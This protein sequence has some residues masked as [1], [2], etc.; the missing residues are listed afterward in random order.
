MLRGFE[1]SMEIAGKAKFHRFDEIDKGKEEKQR[2]IT[3]N[4][5]H[6]GYSS[7][8]RRYAH[9]DCPGHRDFIKNM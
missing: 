7:E 9:T 1:K 6:V 4:I 8:K 2:G 5:A 3:I